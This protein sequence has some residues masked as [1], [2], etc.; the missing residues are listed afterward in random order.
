[1]SKK[2]AREGVPAKKAEAQKEK[3]TVDEKELLK[4]RLYELRMLG[5]AVYLGK[6]GMDFIYMEDKK[7]LRG[8]HTFRLLCVPEG[9]GLVIVSK[10]EIKNGEVLRTR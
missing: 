4:F 10:K 2:V 3:R 8:K 7:G 1:M 6:W 9:D 5:T